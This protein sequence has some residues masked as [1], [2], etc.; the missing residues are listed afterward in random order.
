MT[1]CERCD[2]EEAT[3]PD[4]EEATDPDREEATD[5]D[6]CKCDGDTTAS[7]EI[8]RALCWARYNGDSSQWCNG[9]AVNW[10]TRCLAAESLSA[11][12]TATVASLTE[13][14]RLLVAERDQWRLVALRKE[15][16]SN[17]LAKE[18]DLQL[19]AHETC[20]SNFRALQKSA[21][22]SP[23]LALDAIRSLGE[24][25][26]RWMASE[27]QPLEWRIKEAK[28][29]RDAL[30]ARC[31]SMEVVL[32]DLYADAIDIREDVSHCP[33][34]HGNSSPAVCLCSKVTAREERIAR[35]VI[36]AT[37]KGEAQT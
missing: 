29:E 2:R 15:E 6:V 23:A 35:I 26:R 17:R 3:D 1:R 37:E 20:E 12:L 21:D 7:C 34:C 10:R 13:V 9:M 5:P 28:V 14:N 27:R 30:K 33:S 25:V 24:D 19:A 22:F 31:E 4:R 18:L 11:D 36:A 32:A 16:Q 8:C